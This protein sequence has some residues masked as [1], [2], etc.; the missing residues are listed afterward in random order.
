MFHLHP[1]IYYDKHDFHLI[2]IRVLH[3]PR[4]TIVDDENYI[5]QILCESTAE[6]KNFEN[7][8]CAGQS[9]PVVLAIN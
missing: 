9:L 1:N 5:L 8:F 6:L 7:F 4:C 2:H 3:L